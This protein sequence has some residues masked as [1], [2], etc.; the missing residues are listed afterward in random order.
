MFSTD[1]FNIADFVVY[2]IAMQILPLGVF[3]KRIASLRTP[4]GS[5][6]IDADIFRMK[7]N[8]EL[9]EVRL[10]IKDVFKILI[11]EFGIIL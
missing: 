9:T 4:Y 1:P 10:K 11:E 8:G 3:E 2:N 5:I 6:S 7:K